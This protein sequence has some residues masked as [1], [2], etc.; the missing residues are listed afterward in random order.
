MQK[1]K[2]IKIR[3]KKLKRICTAHAKDGK[4]LHCMQ[5]IKKKCIPS[6]KKIKKF[7]LPMQ[8]LKIIYIAMQIIKKNAFSGNT[9]INHLS[10]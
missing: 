1:I 5:K 10:N 9:V 3:I 8:K 7:A 4:K 6:E 2:R